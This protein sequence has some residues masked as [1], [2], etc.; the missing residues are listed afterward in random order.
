[1]RKRRGGVLKDHGRK[2]TKQSTRQPLVPG[3]LVAIGI[4]PRL[5]AFAY[6]ADTVPSGPVVLTRFFPARFAW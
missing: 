2:P 5:D 4:L 3:S 6:A 1:M